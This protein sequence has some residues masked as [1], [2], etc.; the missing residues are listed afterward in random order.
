MSVLGC[1]DDPCDVVA[2]RNHNLAVLGPTIAGGH[3]HEG[4]DVA[5][6]GIRLSVRNQGVE[7]VPH[8]HHTELARCRFVWAQWEWVGFALVRHGSQPSADE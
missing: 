1:D 2:G 4:F 5:L 8:Q 3:P 6:D 7:L